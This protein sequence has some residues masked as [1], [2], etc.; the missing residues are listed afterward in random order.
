QHVLPEVRTGDADGLRDRLY[1]HALGLS[2]DQEARRVVNSKTFG[3]VDLLM[4][5][6]VYWNL[7]HTKRRS[8]LPIQSGQPIQHAGEKSQADIKVPLIGLDFA[9]MPWTKRAKQQA[10]G[11]SSGQSFRNQG[12]RIAV[13]LA[14]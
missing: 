14:Q 7:E 1:D 2:C 12:A 4:A 3:E 13:L 6:Q 10:Q 5:V 9:T 8:E 11:K